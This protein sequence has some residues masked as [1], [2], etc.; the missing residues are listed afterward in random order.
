MQ[1]RDS[2]ASSFFSPILLLLPHLSS[3]LFPTYHKDKVSRTTFYPFFLQKKSFF[4]FTLIPFISSVKNQKEIRKQLI[5][6]HMAQITF[7]L[8]DGQ[9]LMAAEVS[10]YCRELYG[11]FYNSDYRFLFQE[12]NSRRKEVEKFKEKK[13]SGVGGWRGGLR[14]KYD[15]CTHIS[16]R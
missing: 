4:P 8:V 10:Q 1:K 15:F 16:S 11:E 12:F 3:F 5:N 7:R 2:L 9:R 14:K 13:S 6:S